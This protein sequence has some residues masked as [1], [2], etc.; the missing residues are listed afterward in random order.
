MFSLILDTTVEIGNRSVACTLLM[1]EAARTFECEFCYSAG[2]SCQNLTCI[3]ATETPTFL[4]N[5]TE[6]TYCY[7][8]TTRVND[9]AVAVIQD[10]FNTGKHG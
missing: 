3:P 6:L 4:P 8:A 2:D 1:W 7:R 9:T 10:T 5:L